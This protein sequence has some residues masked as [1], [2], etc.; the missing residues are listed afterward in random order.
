MSQRGA[1]SPGFDGGIGVGAIGRVVLFGLG[2]VQP[3]GASL[4]FP[5]GSV[6][7]RRVE[8]TAPPPVRDDGAAAAA[9]QSVQRR[10]RRSAPNER[11]RRRRE[12]TPR[13]RCDR[14]CARADDE[15]PEGEGRLLQDG[16]AYREYERAA[17]EEGSAGED[18]RRRHR[19]RLCV[20]GS[21]VRCSHTTHRSQHQKYQVQNPDVWSSINF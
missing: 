1:N 7:G 3:A 17:R 8:R 21:L 18:H 6:G 20:D 2:V 10:G 16:G 13:S 11:R 19:H 4:V 14:K 5:R 15:G 9:S 12:G